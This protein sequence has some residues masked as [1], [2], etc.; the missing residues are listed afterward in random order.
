[1]GPGASE[2]YQYSTTNGQPT[3]IR[4]TLDGTPY[5]FDLAY[6]TLGRLDVLTYPTSSASYRFKVDYDYDSWGNL[7]VAK[8]GDTGAPFYTLN[9]GDALSRAVNVHLG[10]GLDEYRT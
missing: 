4:Q 5:D 1:S 6:D 3:Q 7:T 9:E 2:L 8:D 10:N